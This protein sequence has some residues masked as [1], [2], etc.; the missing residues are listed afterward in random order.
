MDKPSWLR[1]LNDPALDGPVNMARDEALLDAVGQGQAPATLRLYQWSSPTISLGYF[2]PYAAYEALPSPAGSL[3]VVRRLTGGGAILHD[4]ELTYSIVFPA[5]HPLVE[6]GAHRLYELAHEGIIASLHRLGLSA[7]PSGQTDDSSARSGPFFCFDRR[8]RYDL[9]IGKKKIAGSAQRRRRDAVLQ[10]GSIILG[11]RYA[12]QITAKLDV[13]FDRSMKH[14]P[15]TV[16]SAI[17]MAMGLTLVAG[18]W[19]DREIAALDSLVT[20]YADDTWSRRT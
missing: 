17:A 3:P 14:A 15:E 10:H 20:K 1:L 5:G 19:S 2:Q 18:A 9:V 7:A 13:P 4:L 16:A 11:N 6:G 8:H 12:Q